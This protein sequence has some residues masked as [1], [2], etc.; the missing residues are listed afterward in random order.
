MT[1]GAHA[2]ASCGHE[3]DETILIKPVLSPHGSLILRLR[4]KR[5]RRVYQKW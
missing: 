5:D 2:K 1:D 4:Q 3:D